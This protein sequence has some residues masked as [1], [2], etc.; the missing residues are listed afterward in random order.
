[1]TKHEKNG[2]I[3]L[4]RR[5]VLMRGGA[6]ILGTLIAASTRNVAHAQTPSVENVMANL[7]TIT[8]GDFN[9]NYANQW[10]FRLA[11]ALGF[12][13][14]GGIEN[15]EIVLTDEYVPGLVGRSLDIAHGDTSAFLAAGTASGL[16]ITM[17]SMHRDKEW[18]IMG[19]REG[20]E[21]VDDL[22]GGTITGGSLAGRNTWIMRQVMK[23]MGL[24][25]DTDMQFVPASGGSDSR[26]GALL[27]GSVDAA[28]LFPRHQAPLTEAGGKF[29]Y[30]ELVDAPQEAF[31]VMGDWLD[32]N[33][34][35]M[36]AWLVADLK[37][38]RW[39]KDPANK[40][41]AYQIMVD[42]GYDIPESFRDLYDVEL[43]Q[44]STDGGF[45]NAEVMDDFVRDLAVTG[46]LPEGL[47]WRPYFN[48]EYLWKAQEALGGSPRPP[49]L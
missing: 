3:R 17:V 11:Q 28:S 19:V 38:R 32:D 18:W 45:E 31:A 8:L 2:P 7:D 23:R 15:L 1:M 13:E 16:P 44:L 27:N 40:E 5:D 33:A 37:A 6:G 41:R 26:L 20:I 36:Q 12:L 46:V 9:P 43:A 4:A 10:P 30:E 42:L 39:L 29:L 22:R 35:T 48:F 24:D 34:D 47:D 25:P 14:D 21:T 49:A